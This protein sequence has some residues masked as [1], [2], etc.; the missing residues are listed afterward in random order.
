MLYVAH[1][2][3]GAKKIFSLIRRTRKKRV[4]YCMITTEFLK[5]S[6]AN[7]ASLKKRV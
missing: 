6:I 7:F 1:R 2:L 4:K 3:I 5:S